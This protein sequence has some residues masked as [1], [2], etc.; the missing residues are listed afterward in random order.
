MTLPLRMCISTVKRNQSH[1]Q[2]E[3]LQ[4]HRLPQEVPSPLL[5]GPPYFINTRGLKAVIYINEQDLYVALAHLAKK[6]LQ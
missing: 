3:T 5:V 1:L 6:T 2:Q 4:N